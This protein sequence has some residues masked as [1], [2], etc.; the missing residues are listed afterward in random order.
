MGGF[1]SF[2]NSKQIPIVKL[3]IISAGINS[4]FGQ[5]INNFT[6]GIY[7]MSPYDDFC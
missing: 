2:R 1:V 6:M 3:S 4:N 5:M 7:E